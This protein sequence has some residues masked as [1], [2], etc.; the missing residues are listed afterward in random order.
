MQDDGSVRFIVEGTTHSLYELRFHKINHRGD[1]SI[2][3]FQ[4]DDVD[5][6]D[7]KMDTQ[8][9]LKKTVRFQETLTLGNEKQA[10]SDISIRKETMYFF[11][12]FASLNF[13]Y[14]QVASVLGGGVCPMFYRYRICPLD[15]S[16][17]NRVYE[18]EDH[19]GRLFLEEAT[20]MHLEHVRLIESAKQ[21]KKNSFSLSLSQT[22]K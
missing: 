2:A 15:G 12:K 9:T 19:V 17:L 5:L 14:S 1:M 21:H 3:S 16:K 18:V 11:Q 7:E 20:Q 13:Y 8:K 4:V 6:N 10:L 22:D